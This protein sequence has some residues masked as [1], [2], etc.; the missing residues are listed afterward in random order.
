MPDPIPAAT[1]GTPTHPVN[2]TGFATGTTTVRSGRTA[3]G[4]WTEVVV[5]EQQVDLWWGWSLILAIVLLTALTVATLLA[6]AGVQRLR[7]GPQPANE[8]RDEATGDHLLPR[9]E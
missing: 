4:T 6:V 7:R 1:P 3:A 8:S 5:V 2:L 9:R